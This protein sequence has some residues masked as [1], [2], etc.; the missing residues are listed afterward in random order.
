MNF[1]QKRLAVLRSELKAVGLKWSEAK[2][3]DK[4]DKRLLYVI[5]K[6]LINYPV[7]FDI[8]F[9]CDA[10]DIYSVSSSKRAYRINC[11]ST[12]Y[13]E[14]RKEEEKKRA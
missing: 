11:W 12:Y 4:Y 5:G 1:R 8:D 7:S 9:I 10:L 6:L 13:Q 2:Q 3:L 14:L